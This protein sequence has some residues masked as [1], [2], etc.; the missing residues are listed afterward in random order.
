[1]CPVLSQR[2]RTSCLMLYSP[3]AGAADSMRRCISPACTRPR[4]CTPGGTPP[5]AVKEGGRKK[6]Q[7]QLI[8]E[9][10]NSNAALVYL[11]QHLVVYIS[12]AF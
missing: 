1:M 2:P 3:R 10:S 6:D 7:W 9:Q 11:L 12:C 5:G 4:R 8:V